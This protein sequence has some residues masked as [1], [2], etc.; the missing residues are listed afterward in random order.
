[1]EKK[2]WKIGEL[3]EVTGVTIRALHHYHEK[4]LLIPSEISETGYRIYSKNDMIKLQQIISLKQFSFNLDEIKQ[5]LESKNFDPIEI[6]KR[7]INITNEE[8]VKKEK[9]KSQLELFSTILLYRETKVEDFIKLIGVFAMDEIKLEIGLQ[10]V[11]LVEKGGK[12]LES[13]SQLRKEK[14]FPP[15][16]VRDN[17]I[18]KENE[19][20]F[21]TKGKE[22]F[23]GECK[24][25]DIFPKENIDSIVTKLEE[26][27]GG[28]KKEL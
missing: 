13:I 6:I 24:N 22:V 15:V 14:V 28:N 11:P 5:I 19:Y 23:R 1:M 21:I 2:T 16:N 7:Q 4:G 10:L 8:I 27:I 25:A 17:L 26:I 20:R 3:S 9:L 18:L 12:L